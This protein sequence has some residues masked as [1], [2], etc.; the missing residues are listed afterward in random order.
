MRLM[1]TMDSCRFGPRVIR[2]DLRDRHGQWERA[3]SQR[4]RMSAE[5]GPMKS[6]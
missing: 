4:R 5:K 2:S 1:T 6:Q 3:C